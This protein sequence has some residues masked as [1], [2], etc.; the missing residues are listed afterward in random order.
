MSFATRFLYIA[1]ELISMFQKAPT[2]GARAGIYV[3]SDFVGEAR[4]VDPKEIAEVKFFSV[5]ELP[6]DL[7]IGHRKR[8]DEYL[9]HRVIEPRW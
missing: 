3:V 9:G 1:K 7:W 6:V 8:I 5:G 4:M 2:L